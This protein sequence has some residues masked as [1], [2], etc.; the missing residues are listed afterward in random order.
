MR[1]RATTRRTPTHP[2]RPRHRLPRPPRPPP[3]PGRPPPLA[4]TPAPI[5]PLP[6]TPPAMSG[7]TP[8][9]AVT[10]AAMPQPVPAPES[11][12]AAQLA[13]LRSLIETYMTP[14]DV[15]LIS[16]A[17]AFAIEKHA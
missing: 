6:V 1:C 13:L 12:A 16:D 9:L 14:E 5:A 7:P 15:A 11:P 8:P 10:P 17:F 2:H 3:C 4:L